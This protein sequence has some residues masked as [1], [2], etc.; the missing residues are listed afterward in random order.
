[1]SFNIDL[2]MKNYLLFFSLILILSCDDALFD[3]GIIVTKEYKLED[4]SEIYIEDIFD[5]FL[6]QDTIC[7][8]E[9][10][11]GDNLLPNIDFKVKDKEFH[12]K[13]KNGS[14]WSRNYEKIK[15]YITLK[16]ITFL[17]VDESANLST[18]DTLVLPKLT[19][20][21]IND[22]S[23]INL[24]IKSNNFSIVNESTSGG[25]FTIKGETV[26]SKIWARGSCIIDAYE[27]KSVNT[28][29]KTESIGDCAINVSEKLKVEISRTGDVYYKGKPA[30]ITYVNEKAK[31]Q[32][33]K[34]D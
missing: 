15:V 5:V 27:L 25:Y 12:I 28:N 4:F 20:Q 22:Y 8:L 26:N 13:N 29:I 11:G 21:S 17:K 32:L 1:M 10:E 24:T 30:E 19:V 33:I 34:I 31:D 23:D 9:L 7:K 16:D 3:S 2:K 6:I 14:N 18:I